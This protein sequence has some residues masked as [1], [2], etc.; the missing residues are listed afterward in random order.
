MERFVWIPTF[1]ARK[2]TGIQETHFHLYSQFAHFS[3]GVI[4]V[5]EICNVPKFFIFCFV[6]C[7]GCI[8]WGVGG[9]GGGNL[10]IGTM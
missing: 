7:L 2:Y 6:V 1:Q 8:W 5:N 4:I 10:L 3:E 9:L